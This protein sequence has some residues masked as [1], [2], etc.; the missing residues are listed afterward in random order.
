MKPDSITIYQMELPFNT[1]ISKDVM[2]GT[3]QFTQPLAGWEQKRRW[4]KEAFEMLEADGYHI[5]SAYTASRDPSKTTFLYRDRLWQGADM[6]GLGVASFGHMNG[7]H[8]QN[9][10][11]WETYSGAVAKGEIPLNRAYRPTGEERMIREFIL[12][13]KR[14]SIQPAYFQE[15]YNVN[16]LER[17]D[18]Q[19]ASLDEAGYLTEANDRI[20]AL[21]RDGLLRVD[22]LLP[23]FFLP[24]HTGIRY[25]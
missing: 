8:I 13:L 18:A 4:V 3:G 7:V 2:K 20:V 11:T 10:D 16:V 5:G 22:S 6:A 14:G 21:T 25:T 1:T 23:R 19:L 24:Q 12:Q 17:F 15:K 9:F